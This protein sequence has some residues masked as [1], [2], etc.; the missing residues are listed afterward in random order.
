MKYVLNTFENMENGAFLQK[1][2]CS[3]FHIFFKYMKFQRPQKA[4][5]WSK[6]LWLC[7][8]C[9]FMC[10]HLIVPDDVIFSPNYT[11]CVRVLCKGIKCMQSPHDNPDCITYIIPPFFLKK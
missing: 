1:S 9:K 4:L 3:I 6:G 2:K 8:A 7:G 10:R 11:A 5:L